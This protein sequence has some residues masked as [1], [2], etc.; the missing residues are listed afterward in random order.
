MSFNN[1]LSKKY[2]EKIAKVS[3]RDIERLKNL[4]NK[5]LG[6]VGFIIANGPSLANVNFELLK[7]F[8]TIGMNR[9]YLLKSKV[10]FTPTY[11][12]IEDRLE[13]EQE[14]QNIINQTTILIHSAGIEYSKNFNEKS[15]DQFNKVI[16]VKVAG[17]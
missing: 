16:D 7:S 2:Y 13:A 5:H 10:N 12:C 3:R 9:V 15:Y 14:Y 8:P 4:H 1:L 6:E 11:Y 17:L